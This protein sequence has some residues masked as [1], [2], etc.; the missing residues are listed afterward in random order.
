VTSR[1]V[2]LKLCRRCSCLDCGRILCGATKQHRR[3]CL[4][5][6]N[7]IKCGGSVDVSLICRVGL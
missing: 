5:L 4:T 3:H 6:L 7:D 2:D 1:V